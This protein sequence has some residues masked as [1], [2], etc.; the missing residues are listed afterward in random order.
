[1]IHLI[2]WLIII[3]CSL[4]LIFAYKFNISERKLYNIRFICS[5]FLIYFMS[6]EIET[7]LQ[8]SRIWAFILSIS[9]IFI[10][11]LVSPK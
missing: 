9:F 1:M 4:I 8:I 5:I 10:I 6:Y 11:K 3:I 7:S 2:Y